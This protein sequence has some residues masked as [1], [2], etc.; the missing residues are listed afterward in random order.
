MLQNAMAFEKAF[1]DAGGLLAAGVDPTGI[2]GALP[3]YGDQRNYEMLIEGGFTPAQAVQVVSANGARILGI[4]DRVGSIEVGKVADL[5]VLNGDLAA[6]RSVIRNVTIVFKGGI[7]YDA[8]KLIE[9][10]K[11]RVGIS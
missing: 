7:G 1:F 4:H 6:D 10:V 9:S 8:A 3:G 5:V 11:G 2:G